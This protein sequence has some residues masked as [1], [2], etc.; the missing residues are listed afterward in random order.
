MNEEEIASLRSYLASQ[1][2]RRVPGH[3]ID[4]LQ[5]TYSEFVQAILA[6]P[7]S[8]FRTSHKGQW[9]AAEVLEHVQT[10]MVAYEKSI[11][12]VLEYGE[13][14]EAQTEEIS[15][16]IEP[17]LRGATREQLLSALEASYKRLTESVRRADPFVHLDIM[18]SHFELGMMHW[19]EWLLFV[20]VHLIEHVRQVKA[21]AVAV[22]DQ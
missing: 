14:P 13:Q 20:R 5:A 2:M 19:R 15:G 11:C 18:W 22:T 17:I 6:I 7:D 16:A 8:A 12:M 9:S 1:S 4:A 10:V 21:V 3:L